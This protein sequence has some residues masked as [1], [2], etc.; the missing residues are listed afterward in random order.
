MIT[1]VDVPLPRK[2]EIWCW[3]MWYYLIVVFDVDVGCH[4]ALLWWNIFLWRA[5]RVGAAVEILAGVC[6]NF[7]G[8][9]V[10]ILAGVWSKFWREIIQ[11]ESR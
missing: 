7:G 5:E 8:M 6:W 1:E 3:W 11:I 10:E 4:C 9:S 2:V